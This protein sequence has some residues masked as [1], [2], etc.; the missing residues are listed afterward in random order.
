MKRLLSLD[1]GIKN[2]AYCIID[3]E[4]DTF[5]DD[6]IAKWTIINW[7]CVDILK[8]AYPDVYMTCNHNTKNGNKCGCKAL[9]IYKQNNLEYGVC[10]RHIKIVQK[11]EDTEIIRKC[12]IP[13]VSK[14]S[15]EIL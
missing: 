4:P 7:D 1:I 8:T 15:N 10:G 6:S 9:K 12:K 14:L 3:Y 13:K 2:L 5:K 11:L